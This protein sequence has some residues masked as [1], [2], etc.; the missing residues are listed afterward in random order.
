MMREVLRKHEVSQGRYGTI[1]NSGNLAE[2]VGPKTKR[3]EM[4][5][6]IELVIDYSRYCGSFEV[7]Q[8]KVKCFVPAGR[9]RP[10]PRALSN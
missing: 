6:S 9:A 7:L 2:M 3:Q 10:I 8:A 4:E 5:N 1:D